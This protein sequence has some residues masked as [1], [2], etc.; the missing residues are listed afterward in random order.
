[1]ETIPQELTNFR[2]GLKG[3]TDGMRQASSNIQSKISELTTATETAKS[4][5][6]SNYDSSNKS[7]LISSIG[8]INSDNS[9][10]LSVLSTL[11]SILES[12]DTIVGNVDSLEEINKLIETQ[13]QVINYE[14]SLDEDKKSYSNIRE[15]ES[16][17]AEKKELFAALLEETIGM[18]QKLKTMDGEISL[19]SSEISIS[20]LSP[21]ASGTYT[22]AETFVAS[23]GMKVDYYI[24]VPENYE[25]VDGL[26]LHMYFPGAGELRNVNGTGLP[27]YLLNG[28]QSSGVVLCIQPNNGANY[29]NEAYFE[30]VKEL[31][32]SVVSTYNVDTDKISTSGHSLGGGACLKFA[33]QYPDYFS[34]VAPVA[35]YDD[36]LSASEK[37]SLNIVNEII[38]IT[39]TH[40]GKSYKQMSSLEEFLNGNM[41]FI[42][43]DLVRG[44]HAIHNPL[45]SESVTINGKTYSNLL[46]FC[47]SQSKKS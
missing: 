30:A 33:S 46:E 2:D 36:T 17:I 5:I 23:N 3:K 47:L 26:G 9:S 29:K 28:Q 1:M 7:K 45:Y 34:V 32:D 38:A 12:A 13:E 41:E 43:T 31:S 6:D 20:T 22:K 16:I 24:Y 25:S 35:G 10:I 27:Y 39:G 44:L 15:A 19:S 40:D 21:E 8:K 11:N 37:S 18:L 42:P 14:N 4:G